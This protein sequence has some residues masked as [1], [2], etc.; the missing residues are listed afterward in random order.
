MGQRPR[1]RQ[2]RTWLAAALDAIGDRGGHPTGAASACS[3]RQ[4]SGRAAVASEQAAV[5]QRVGGR[6]G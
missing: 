1:S 4:T 2:Q 6:R 3:R 5:S